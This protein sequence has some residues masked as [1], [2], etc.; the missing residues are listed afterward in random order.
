MTDSKAV[1]VAFAIENE[2]QRDFLNGQCAKVGMP[3][4]GSW[5]HSLWRP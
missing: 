1:F 2:R 5:A 3:L 4:R